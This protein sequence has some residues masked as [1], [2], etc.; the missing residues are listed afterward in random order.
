MNRL[1]KQKFKVDVVVM[2]PPRTGSDIKFLKA[3]VSLR[4]EKLVYV[5]CNPETLKRDLDFISKYYKVNSIQPVDM[6]PFTEHLE[7]VVS[8]KLI[9]VKK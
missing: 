1:A 5:S 2:D 9:G 7:T 6:F 8:M 4:P 3:V